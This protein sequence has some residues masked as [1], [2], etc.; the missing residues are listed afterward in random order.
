MDLLKGLA[1]RG[2]RYGKSSRVR[3]VGQ[4][5]KFTD[6]QKNDIKEVLG[7]YC[8]SDKFD[9]FIKRIEKGIEYY[10]LFKDE[11]TLTKPK[12]VVEQVKKLQKTFNKL[13]KQLDD[14]NHSNESLI[15]Q[16]YYLRERQWLPNTN[17]RV[18]I[19]WLGGCHA[20]TND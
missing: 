3:R 14:L 6:Y 7:N 12:E 10:N 18:V 2:T 11:T 19:L 20:N 1:L 5:Y 17:A 8:P 9:L 16:Y 15:D 4:E 13:S